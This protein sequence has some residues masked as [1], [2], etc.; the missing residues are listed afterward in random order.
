MTRELLERVSALEGT[1]VLKLAHD[2]WLI[3]ISAEEASCLEAYGYIYAQLRIATH[4]KKIL[5]VFADGR[6]GNLIE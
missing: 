1:R 4:F 3:V 2:R 6:V 5:M